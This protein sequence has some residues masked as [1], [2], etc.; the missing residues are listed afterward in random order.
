MHMHMLELFRNAEAPDDKY[1]HPICH[2]DLDGGEHAAYRSYT[3]YRIL[4]TR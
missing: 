1:F 3:L 4:G 2:F